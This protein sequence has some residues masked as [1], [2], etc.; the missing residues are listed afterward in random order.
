MA[1]SQPKYRILIKGFIWK[2]WRW[3]F[4]FQALLIF[5]ECSRR[6]NFKAWHCCHSS[7]SCQPSASLLNA[8]LTT[9]CILNQQWISKLISKHSHHFKC[10][11]SHKVTT[12]VFSK[13]DHDHVWCEP[14]RL[15][16]PGCWA[17]PPGW[18]PMQR[19]KAIT[20]PS[21][22]AYSPTTEISSLTRQWCITL[23]ITMFWLILCFFPPPPFIVK[24]VG[25]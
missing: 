20:L 7:P 9:P 19:W 2:W 1:Q 18:L 3:L 16:V 22:H 24:S 6:L 14:G 17:K 12:Q 8:R 13:P 25:A 11:V 4:N 23:G 21:V 15:C 5:W 10:L